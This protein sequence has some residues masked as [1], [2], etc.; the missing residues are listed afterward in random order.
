MTTNRQQYWQNILLAIVLAALGGWLLFW[1]AGVLR[2]ELAA[3]IELAALAEL[4]ASA[5][6]GLPI[7][8]TLLAL[9]AMM[10]AGVRS[11]TWRKLGL[12]VALGALPFVLILPMV[13]L[14]GGGSY[15][16]GKGYIDCPDEPGSRLYPVVRKVRPESLALCSAD[17]SVP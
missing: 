8:V 16:A 15:L 13:L 5:A 17:G 4:Q 14:L 3:L 6:I 12:A 7:G 11:V 2:A 10:T 1:S 9:L